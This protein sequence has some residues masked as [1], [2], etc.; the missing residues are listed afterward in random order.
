MGLSEFVASHLGEKVASW[1]KQVNR[2]ADNAS[3]EPHSLY[4]AFVVK[5]EPLTV[6]RR[7]IV[8]WP[9]ISSSEGARDHRSET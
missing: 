2:L 4:A 8:K 5:L 7:E 6:G 1:S 3:I 9:A